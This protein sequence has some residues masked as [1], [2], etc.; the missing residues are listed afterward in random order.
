MH[1]QGPWC[2]PATSYSFHT[3]P[4]FEKY[5]NDYSYVGGLADAWSKVHKSM[6]ILQESEHRGA[7][8]ILKEDSLFLSSPAFGVECTKSEGTGVLQLRQERFAS[9]RKGWRSG[10]KPATWVLLHHFWV[11]RNCFCTLSPILPWIPGSW[12][13]K[14]KHYPILRDSETTTQVGRGGDKGARRAVNTKSS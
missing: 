10:E 14:T 2:S 1:C 4:S 13:Y 11:D 12:R 7:K 6:Y 5:L 8:I 3:F 9:L